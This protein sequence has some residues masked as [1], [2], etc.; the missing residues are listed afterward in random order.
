MLRG[1]NVTMETTETGPMNHDLRGMHVTL[2]RCKV[3]MET[4][5]PGSIS[6]SH[7]SYYPGEKSVQINMPAAPR[8]CD[9]QKV[10]VS[11]CFHCQISKYLLEPS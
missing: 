9:C 3:T 5:G 7:G 10:C 11:L 1:Y 2:I 8:I 6:C 4:A